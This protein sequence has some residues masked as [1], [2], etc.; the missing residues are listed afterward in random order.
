MSQPEFMLVND[1]TLHL[2]TIASLGL[3]GKKLPQKRVLAA[4][5]MIFHKKFSMFDRLVFAFCWADSIENC[6][7]LFS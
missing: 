7:V 3:Y 1:V 6:G 5:M 4:K 2:T